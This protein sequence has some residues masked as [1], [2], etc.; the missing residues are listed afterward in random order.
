MGVAHI[1]FTSAKGAAR[2]VEMNECTW[3]G[4]WLKVVFHDQMTREDGRYEQMV[5]GFGGKEEKRE[6]ARPEQNLK[7]GPCPSGCT[8]VWIG[9]L[10]YDATKEQIVEAFA[11]CGDVV[12]VQISTDKE[13]GESKGFGHVVF[14]TEEECELSMVTAAKNHGVTVNKQLCRIDYATQ[15]SW[16]RPRGGDRSNGGGAGEEG[17]DGAWSGGGGAV[18]AA[19][20]VHWKKAPTRSRN[21]GKIESFQ[22]SKVKLDS[23]DDEDS[24]SD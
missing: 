15:R 10:P 19:E 11:D 7:P 14:A 16:E 5:H 20:E 4:R 24:D 1:D 23:S 3:C 9:G 17:G 21:R 2:C 22:G 13:T 6:R 12:S 18:V 8:R